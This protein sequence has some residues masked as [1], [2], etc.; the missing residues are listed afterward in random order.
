[1]GR[2]SGCKRSWV[3]SCKNSSKLIAWLIAMS[4]KIS[5]LEWLLIIM[6]FPVRAVLAAACLHSEKKWRGLHLIT[7]IVL[8]AMFVGLQSG[9]SMSLLRIMLPTAATLND[10]WMRSMLGEEEENLVALPTEKGER[11]NSTAAIDFRKN[12]SQPRVSTIICDRSSY[13][14]DV[15]IMKGDIRTHPAS[16]TLFLVSQPPA[17]RQQQEEK[18]RIKPYTRKWENYTMSSVDELSLERT[19]PAHA[20]Q[21]QVTHSVP[22]LVFSTGGYTGNLFHDFTDVIVPLFITSYHLKGQVV[23]VIPNHKP[24]W[25]AKFGDIIRQLSSYE[26][27][28]FREE[29][30]PATHCFPEAI[31]GLR[32]H[33]DLWVD[34][35]LSP[36]KYTI[37]DFQNMLRKAFQDNNKKSIFQHSLL[38]SLRPKLVLIA[39]KGSRVFLNQREI[40]KV[41]EKLGFRVMILSPDVN[42][43]LKDMYKIIN[44]CDVFMGIHGAALTH[45]LFLPPGGVFVQVVPLG[46]EWASRT[47]FRGPATKMDTVEY[48]EYQILP[49]ESSLYDKYP[50][51]HPYLRDPQSVNR[52]GWN[53]TKEVYM[54]NQNVKLHLPRLKRM[55]IK[56]LDL[57]HSKTNANG[58]VRESRK[59]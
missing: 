49:Q 52:R 41:A 23:F 28:D 21:C 5:R 20:P 15:C 12:E 13:R 38:K 29:I 9:C 2:I 26:I 14:T 36:N 39:R 45:F 18:F 25:T 57:L 33:G 1:M 8:V 32:F 27:L 17:S 19:D 55:L 58:G 47:F 30:N 6:A 46:I 22:A 10:D 53:A 7:I 34:P 40:V 43:Q 42:T 16:S 31:V 37:T 24:W 3:E 35:A 56:V 59:S 50:K 44:S 54:D 48:L 4:R 11:Y 51:D